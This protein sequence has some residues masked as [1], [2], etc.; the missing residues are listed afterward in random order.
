MTGP[1]AEDGTIHCDDGW[2]HLL[3][4]EEGSP[5]QAW[6]L[7]PYGESENPSSPH[8]NDL[9][10]LHSK[11]GM[12]QFWLTPEEILAHTESVWGE[13]ERLKKDAHSIP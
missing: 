5:K 2:G 8:F 11:R 7:L 3:V 9:A 6:S 12:K 4:V 1:Q 10:R 13:K